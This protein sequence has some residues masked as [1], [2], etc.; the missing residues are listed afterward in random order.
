MFCNDFHDS[1]SGIDVFLLSILEMETDS[2]I[3]SAKSFSQGSVKFLNVKLQAGRRYV[4]LVIARDR[5]GN[6]VVALSEA[7]LA[8]SDDEYLHDASRIFGGSPAVFRTSLHAT[9]YIVDHVLPLLYS[10]Q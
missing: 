3:A 8:A 10:T 2:I 7:V 5:A 9:V 4:A 1:E 6:E